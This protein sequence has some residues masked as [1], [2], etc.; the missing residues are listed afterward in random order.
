MIIKK[1]PHHSRRRREDAHG[2]DLPPQHITMIRN[3]PRH[4]D[5]MRAAQQGLP[6][7]RSH[8]VQLAR[9]REVELVR[10]DH[11]DVLEQP[12][13]GFRPHVLPEDEAEAAAGVGVVV[14]GDGGPVLPDDVGPAVEVRE[15]VV[16]AFVVRG[17]VVV[18]GD[19]HASVA[20]G[21]EDVVEDTV[22]GSLVFG[23]ES[24]NNILRPRC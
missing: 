2:R 7:I 9:I 12:A 5:A 18:F 4:T 21:D 22:G 20:V 6:V 8:V 15:R 17:G 3:Q 14:A 11:L 23:A 24:V 16:G 19:D 1:I 13:H 10:L